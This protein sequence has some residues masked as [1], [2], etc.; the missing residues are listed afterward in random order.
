VKVIIFIPSRYDS[1]RFPGK[2]LA[3]IGGKP[4]IEHVY[5]RAMS[6]PE[7]SDVVVATDD[8]RILQCVQDFDGKA[9]LTEKKHP[10]GTD[11]IAEASAKMNL[12]RADLVVNIQGDQ[13]LFNPSAISQLILP[14]KEDPHI[15]MSTL[16]YRITN[17]SE[18]ENPNH[19]KVVTD[20]EGFALFF[21]RSPIP[22]FRDARSARVYYKHLGFY[23]YRKDFLEKFNALPMGELESSEKLEQLR[24]L[25]HGFKIKVVETPF[26]SVEVDTPEDIKRVEEIMAGPMATDE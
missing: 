2:P 8:K 4:M 21:S 24:V 19:V 16:K 13:P 23:A 18:I 7:I 25:E 6:C 11:R 15:P 26:D 10:T 1:K 12:D 5:L 22:F 17:E 14:L 9:V 20:G 3:L